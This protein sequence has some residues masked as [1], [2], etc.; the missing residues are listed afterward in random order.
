[1][2]EKS[3]S[4][5]EERVAV[6]IDRANIEISGNDIGIPQGRIDY[7]GLVDYLVAGRHLVGMYVFDSYTC[8]R[9]RNYARLWNLKVRGFTVW[10]ICENGRQKEVDMAMGSAMISG[11][12]RGAFDTAVVLSGDRDFVPAIELVHDCGMRV[13][14]AAFKEAMSDKLALKADTFCT[15]NEIV[16]KRQERTYPVPLNNTHL[17]D[18]AVGVAEAFS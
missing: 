15:I 17:A 10:A 9:D 2:T 8:E 14:A 12:M 13:E 18:A 16:A 3:I 6:F 4:E 5:S 7:G 1:M 11:A